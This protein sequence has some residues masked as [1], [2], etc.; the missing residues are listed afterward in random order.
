MNIFNGNVKNQFKEFK[1]PADGCS[2]IHMIW[3]DS[4]CM[5]TCWNDGNAYIEAV[6]SNDIEFM[7]AQ[8][9]WLENDC[10]MADLILPVVTKFEMDDIGDENNSGIFT[11]LYLE[12]QAC[13]PVGESLSDFDVAARVAEKLGKDYYDA[14]TGNMS[15]ERKLEL[16]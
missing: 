16:W 4:P 2:R 9:P 13:P 5:T 1:F 8:H 15:T 11:S 14:Y 10:L 12:R 6:R 7:V 3:T